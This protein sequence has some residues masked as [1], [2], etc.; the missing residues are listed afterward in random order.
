M[1]F[2][3]AGRNVEIQLRFNDVKKPFLNA[4]LHQ[5]NA[6]QRLPSPVMLHRH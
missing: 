5:Y 3:A 2:K 6:D 1:T 4:E